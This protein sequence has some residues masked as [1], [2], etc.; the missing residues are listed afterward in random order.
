MHKSATWP[1]VVVVTTLAG[2][3]TSQTTVKNISP[4]M[5]APAAP[6]TAVEQNPSIVPDIEIAH[7]IAT[8]NTIL[9]P[10]PTSIVLLKP[11]HDARN[12]AFCNSFF[13]TYPSESEALRQN[14]AQNVLPIFWPE[15]Q[16]DG[17]PDPSIRDSP[18]QRTQKC[19]ALIKNYDYQ[20]AGWYLEAIQ[21]DLAKPTKADPDPAG[22]V[23]LA[24]TNSDPAKDNIVLDASQLELN[25]QMTQ[26]TE[27]TN[28]AK[29]LNDA[30]QAAVAR[31]EETSLSQV[32]K[33]PSS[34]QAARVAVTEPRVTCPT[35]SGVVDNIAITARP[36]S[37]ATVVNP[38]PPRP[39]LTRPA[40]GPGPAP[41]TTTLSTIAARTAAYANPSTDPALAFGCKFVE[42]FDDSI[43]SALVQVAVPG[44]VVVAG[45]YAEK[46]VCSGLVANGLE[47]IGGTQR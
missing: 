5:A 44:I 22:P 32:P 10:M 11:N 30:G 28:F 39:P 3:A 37:C 25:P 21:K 36:L 33:Q 26:G 40:P 38:N 16:P 6:T 20:R 35:V 4:T 23:V 47:L 27:F 18:E 41:P 24:M 19:D 1:L 7:R 42:E 17:L 2:C 46:A 14:S 15:T 43:A 29:A 13:A 8:R 45:K 9:T 34:K 12:L 31:T